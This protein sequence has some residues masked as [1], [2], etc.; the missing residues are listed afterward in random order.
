MCVCAK[1]LQLC[2]TLCDPMN[3]S[4]PGSS[5]HGILQA[6]RLEWVAMP[7]SRGPSPRGTSRTRD[8]TYVSH[9]SYIGRQVLSR[10]VKMVKNCHLHVGDLG[11]SLGPDP[12]EKGL[13]THSSI[14]VWRITWTEE[15][16]GLQ[17]MGSQTAGQ[18]EQLTH[19]Y[20]VPP[21][22]PLSC[23]IPRDKV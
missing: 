18:T 6:R 17:S 10:E 19:T 9:V 12:L 2:L 22:N 5:V 4:R 16:D 21:G 13:A 3:C 23:C 14:L 7:S 20:T 1:S 8:Q 11:W 15:P